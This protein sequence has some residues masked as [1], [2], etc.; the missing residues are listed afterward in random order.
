MR[1]PT[2]AALSLICALCT[3]LPAGPAAAKT[4]R[5]VSDSLEVPLRAGAS[6]RHKIVRMLSS[7]TQVEV[8]ETDTD[9]GFA[10]VRTADGTVQGWVPNQY[11]MEAPSARATLATMQAELERV[12]SET[13]RR[14]VHLRLTP[15]GEAAAASIPHVLAS[16]NNDFLQGF[17]E[18]DWKQLRRLVERMRANVIEAAEQCGILS[19][20]EV[21]EPESLDRFLG[22]RDGQRLLVFCDEDAPISDPM[23]AFAG[24]DRT[25]GTDVLI[26]PEGRIRRV[27]EEAIELLTAP[28][29]PSGTM[30]LLLKPEQMISYERP[31]HR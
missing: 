24:A 26:G 29:C 31:V 16:V 14:V 11:L 15:A 25:K 13:D 28:N 12:R 9:K 10:L 19:L 30:D 7:G 27:A 23:A 22:S 3:L 20:A 2:L 17:S 21:Y 5:Y 8:L 1:R 18:R 4:V 6:L